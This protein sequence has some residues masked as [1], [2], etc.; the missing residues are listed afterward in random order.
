MKKIKSRVGTGESRNGTIDENR[1]AMQSRNGT[2]D[3]NRDAMQSRNGTIDE[4][5]GLLAAQ[6]GCMTSPTRD[7]PGQVSNWL[8]V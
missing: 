4:A 8:M 2:I 7:I 3:E 6:R 1:E 5:G